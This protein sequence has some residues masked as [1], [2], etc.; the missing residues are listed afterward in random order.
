MLRALVIDDEAPARAEMKYLLSQVEQVQVCGEASNVHE[1][2]TLIKATPSDVIFLDIH[3]P[4][5]SGLQLAE[6]LKTH[7][8]PPAI[9]FVTAHSKHALAAF[10][11]NAVDYL[12][13]PVDVGRLEIAINKVIEKGGEADAREAEKEMRITA[14]KGNKK[15]LLA[16]DEIA[17]FMAKDDYC[18]IHT[19]HDH[20][21]S[22]TSLTSFENRLSDHR[23]FRTHRR[24]LVNID[25]ISAVESDVGSSLILTMKD[26]EKSKI[27]V[28]RR[29]IVEFKQLV[30]Y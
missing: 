25:W 16:P 14:S 28:S 6:G 13:K 22:T 10:D 9:I 2:V 23:F 26:D 15:F 5:F 30:G 11:V 29:R 12:M 20:F 21:L 24:Y 7:P 19:A 1:A 8:N 17:Y 3:M 27:P 18:F 4:G